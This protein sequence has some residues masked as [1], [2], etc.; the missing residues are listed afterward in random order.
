MDSKPDDTENADAL[1]DYLRRL[2]AGEQPDR[3]RFL[4]D[5][6]ELGSALNCLELLERMAPQRDDP[7]E[8]AAE[9]LGDFG[10]YELLEEIGRGGMGVVYK[11]RQKTLDRTV[12]IKM[13]LAGH[14]SSPEHLLR[15]QQEARATARLQH[16]N[17]VHIHEVG[18]YEGRQ[19]FA[20]QYVD[21]ISL[22][23][24]IEQGPVEIDEAVRI[25]ATVANAVDHL[26][27]QDIVH[28]DLKPSNILLDAQGQ[29]HVGD[30]G[31]AKIFS[32]DSTITSTGVITGTP[33]YMSPEQ[34]AGRNAQVGPASDIY[35]LGAILY[36]LLTGCPPF[37][38]DSPLDTLLQVL[39]GE[40]VL[41]RS[42]NPKIPRPLQLICLKCMAK[43]PEQRYSSAR[44]LAEDLERFARG[45]PLQARPPSLKDRVLLWSRRQPALASR[46]GALSVFYVIEM[47]NYS[48]ASVDAQFHAK[49]SAI[50]AVW[51]VTSIIFQQF[52]DSRRWSI[53]ARFVWGTLDSV[54]FL[55]V[56]LTADGVAS[57]LLI[58]YP[59]LIVGSGFWFRVRFVT[60]MAVL[61]LISYGV[62]VIDFYY[63]RPELQK[64]F[65]PFKIGIDD[66]VIFVVGLVIMSI[67]VAYLVHRLHM[68]S[69]FC[70]RE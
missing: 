51:A 15:F 39:S 46:L 57:P 10:Q 27:Q 66:H 53:P 6:P 50:V 48:T 30:F 47:F 19:Y 18:Q 2:H 13:V 22:A 7:Q 41:P 61:S 25:M 8:Q 29:P 42:I 5:H 20:M 36:E 35:S 69:R 26:H 49:M 56:M 59:L 70:G 14:L 34:A 37:A 62:L 44:A 63:R 60:Y 21:G 3:S 12:A 58:G 4:G 33:S 55:S 9:T 68:L 11:A 16:P 67:A 43:S 38:E 1:D 52:L 40:P 31:L 23:Q 64:N 45:E 54:L 24:R 17:I 65:Q 32:A 28:R